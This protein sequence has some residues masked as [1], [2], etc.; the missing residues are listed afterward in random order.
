MAL[1]AAAVG[2]AAKGAAVAAYRLFH[3]PF[4]LTA[5]TACDP[6]GVRFALLVLPLFFDLRGIAPHAAAPAVFDALLVFGF[7]AQCFI[8]GLAI[9][10]MTRSVSR[11]TAFLILA[12]LCGTLY[13]IPWVHHDLRGTYSASRDGKT[14][15]TID[16]ECGS[17]DEPIRLDGAVWRYPIG[18]AGGV[19]P[20]SHTIRACG[21]E[22]GFQIPAGVVYRFNYWGP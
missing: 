12:A 17:F 19:E 6:L 9:H 22:I 2:F 13:F 11:R 8:L 1:I 20:G 15:L 16:E 4:L 5:L 7:A 14:Y 21:E 3:P 18:H 10:F